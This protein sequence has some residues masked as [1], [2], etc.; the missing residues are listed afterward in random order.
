MRALAALC[1]LVALLCLPS[2]ARAQQPEEMPSTLVLGF[3]PAENAQTLQRA[4]DEVASQLSDRLHIPVRASV[5][6]DYTTLVESM[7]AGHVH[8]GWLTPSPLVLA[9]RLFGVRVLLTQ[10]RRGK[11]TYFSA[12]VVREASRFRTLDDLRGG[13]IAWIDPT[14]TSGYVIPRYLMIQRGIDPTSFFARQLFAGQHDAAVIAVQRGQVDAAAVWA[15]PPDEGTGA[16]TRYLRGRPG[17]RLRPLLYSP[18]VPSDAVAV[19]EEFARQHPLLVRAISSQ[20]V[21]LGQSAEGRAALGRLNHTDGFVPASMEQYDI[22]RRA[23]RATREER[24]RTRAG[25]FDDPRAIAVFAALALA[26]ALL[27]AGALRRWPRAQRWIAAGVFALALVWSAEAG[28]IPAAEF[29]RGWRFIGQFLRGM[30]PPDMRVGAEV[31]EATVLTIRLALIGTALAVPAALVLGLLAAENVNPNA[32]LRSGA[33]LVC[34]LDRSV[35]LLIVGLILV[36]AYGPGAFPG[37][38]AIALHT[39]GSLGKQF[40]ETLETMDPG[41]VEA[42]RSVGATSTQVIRWGI[43]PQFSPHFIS[44][45]LFRFELN[46]RGAVVLGLVGAQGIGFLLQTY[47]RGAEYSKVTVVIAAIVVLVMALDA[48]SSRLR[49]ETR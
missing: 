22:V 30:V 33:R 43:W 46:V 41:P 44:Q 10:V 35:D 15:D 40:F 13:S 39:V 4:A 21:A 8:V 25:R 26:F 9:E 29:V 38:G 5:T 17:P 37:V 16:W 6:L 45:T 12:L 36:S 20:L 27:S 14:S 23:F 18:P 42:M 7:R 11:P 24:T 3:N 48:V 2:V 19:T 49:R 28:R 34:N 31:L 1:A 32:W 47:M